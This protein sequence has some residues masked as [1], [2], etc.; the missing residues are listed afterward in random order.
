[1]STLR[2][3]I[4]SLYWEGV[5]VA[6]PKYLAAPF[7]KEHPELRNLFTNPKKKN[8]VFA[9][10]KA[11]YAMALSFQEYFPV[12]R[13][14]ILT[15]YN[16]LP[17]EVR[18]KGQMGVWK[19]RESAH[20]LP[21]SNSEKFSREVLI[22]L[23]KLGEDH[24]LIVLLSGGGSSL[25]EIPLPGYT[26]EEIIQF[27][28]G[29]LKQGLPIQDMNL[30][31]MELSS[32]KA[33]KLLKQLDPNLKVF[34]FV[35]S[36]VLGDDPRIISSGP[37]YPGSEYYIMGN[38]SS[39]IAAIG[40]KA[41]RLGYEVK[42]ISDSWDLS[43]EE[44]AKRMV[45]ELTN[46][47]KNPNKQ[48]ILLGGELVCPVNGDGLGGRNQETALRLAIQTESMFS[49]RNW[50]FL[51]AGTDGTDGPTDAAGGI[52]SSE[53]LRMMKEKGW[54]PQAELNRSNSYPILKDSQ[55]LLFTGPTGTNVNDIVILLL[56][57]GN[58]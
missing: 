18:S 19:C 26:I 45:V 12:D 1:M 5:N 39:S 54:D 3:D 47:I 35:I 24:Q 44:T 40:K 30:K 41:I 25:F 28:Q 55:S 43:S 15:K 22:D 13:G 38:L 34:T 8:Y 49:G 50:I 37:S 51:S 16:H 11:A 23:K 32:V 4:E 48:M 31:R 56:A 6:T 33:G 29:L 27:N 52:V 10:G 42:T 57:E 20:P 9:L 53:S 17:E 46:A 36:D 58:P 2:E 14:F 21:D 7:W